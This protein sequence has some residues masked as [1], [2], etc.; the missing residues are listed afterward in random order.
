MIVAFPDDAEPRPEPLHTWQE[1]GFTVAEARGWIKEGFRLPQARRWRESGVYAADQ[2]RQWRTAGATPYTVDV[3]LRAGMTPR[4]A[5]R[6]RELGHS[7]EEAADRHLAGE[8][9]RPRRWLHRLFGG[10]RSRAAEP[11]A[12]RELLRAGVAAS[13][14]RGFADAGWAG[15][16]AVEWARRGVAPTDARIFRA[17]GFSAAEAEKLDED[18]IS[19]MVGWW[20]AGV[21]FD[22][23]AA[24]RG[25]GF[26][27]GE[28]MVLRADGTG[29]EQAKI[30]RALSDGAE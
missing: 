24:W 3:C 5:V 22:E 9:P 30:L 17:L 6:W 14:A 21:P 12:M 8:S 19:V 29:V 10:D 7:L 28:A 4:D 15:R 18:A 16:D 2:A 20:R 26:Q 27:P 13:T 23:V 11:G 25:A 1:H